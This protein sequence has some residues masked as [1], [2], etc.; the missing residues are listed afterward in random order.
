ME[1]YSQVT[2]TLEAFVKNVETM[3]QAYLFLGSS[4]LGTS[5]RKTVED[6]AAKITGREIPNIDIVA[7]DAQT[8]GGI[9]SLREAMQ[10]ASLMPA[11]AKYKTVVMYN[12]QYA[13]VQ[14]Q[15][16][17]LK[18]LEEPPKRTVFLLLSSL[19]LLPTI[20]SRCQ[21]FT[22]ARVA[23]EE[24]ASDELS[25]AMLKLDKNKSAGLAE[26]TA[27]VNELAELEDVV[28][29]QLIESWLHKQVLELKQAP[30]KFTAVRVTLETLESLR[31][32]FNKKMVLQKFVTTGLL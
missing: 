26:K 10:L 14:M 18:R 28:L 1:Q 2:K 15:N 29:Q 23:G 9:D 27:L 32:N 5:S 3:P 21:N 8:E 31:G 30:K 20:V 11:E 4:E 22:L 6:F 19:P 12:M 7:Y 17:L 25:E 24:E 16:A 13:N